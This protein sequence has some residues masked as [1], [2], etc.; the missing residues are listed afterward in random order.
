MEKIAL[1]EFDRVVNEMPVR[2]FRKFF[3]EVR[4]GGVFS[5]VVS[6]G[7]GRLDELTDGDTQKESLRAK[8]GEHFPVELCKTDENLEKLVT[9]IAGR[10]TSLR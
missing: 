6:S 8:L 10:A 7:I 5:T 1:K 2:E 9:A 3:K 4:K